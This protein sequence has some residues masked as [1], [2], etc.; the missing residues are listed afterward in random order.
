MG[1]PKKRKLPGSAAG[2]RGAHDGDSSPQ[3]NN[4]KNDP[5]RSRVAARKRRGQP[6]GRLSLEQPYARPRADAKLVKISGPKQWPTSYWLVAVGLFVAFLYSYWPTLW[7]MADSW[8]NEP[9]YSHGWVVPVLAGMICY[10]RIESFPGVTPKAAWAG[11]SLIALAIL[12]RFVSRLAYADFL[13]GWS[14]LPLVAGVVWCL[15]GFKAM[16]WSLP[17]VGFLI[18]AVPMPYQAERMLSWRLQGVATELSTIFLRVLG[19][20]AVAHGHVVWIGEEELSIE[21]ACSGLRIFVGMGA[22]AYFWAAANVRSW[23]DK[24]VILVAAIPAAILVNS[25]RIVL[26]GFGYLLFESDSARRMIHDFSG[27]AMIFASFGIMWL[28]SVYW[29]H[30]YAPVKK[31][32]AREILHESELSY[33]RSSGG[34]V[35]A[36]AEAG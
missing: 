24:I 29:Q 18:F 7:W 14:I 9:D 25:A 16:L 12:M 27:I 10:Y 3:Q 22:F 4:P 1:R 21:E 36:P 23:S 5:G 11:L 34:G 2:K 15:L 30:L 17:A 35:D 28:V 26:I 13:D 8:I 20:P 33:R 31:L 32:T 6:D 19:Q